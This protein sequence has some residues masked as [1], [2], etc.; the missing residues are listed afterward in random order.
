MTETHG[1]DINETISVKGLDFS[2]QLTIGAAKWLERVT[3][4]S[5]T[6]AAQELVGLDGDNF[7]VTKVAQ[8]LTALY[9]AAHPGVDPQ[10]AEAKVDALGFTDMMEVLG[11]ARPM[12]FEAKNSPPV[13]PTEA[14]TEELTGPSSSIT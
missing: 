9:I 7:E 2:A 5:I 6:K 1:T 4:K 14:P 11:R 10:E 12:D 3:G 8:L 13:P